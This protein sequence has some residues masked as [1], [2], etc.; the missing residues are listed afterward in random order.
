MVAVPQNIRKF[1]G[2][3]CVLHNSVLNQ[4]PDWPHQTLPGAQDSV[5]NSLGTRRTEANQRTEG[6]AALGAGE[7]DAGDAG[8]ASTDH[9]GRKKMKWGTFSSVKHGMIHGC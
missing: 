2:L 8:D 5:K 1:A 3:H 9:L 6:E 4:T 7:G